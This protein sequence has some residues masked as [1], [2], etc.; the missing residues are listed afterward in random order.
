MTKKI[1]VFRQPMVSTPAANIVVAPRRMWSE[2]AYFIDY[3]KTLTAFGSPAQRCGVRQHDQQSDQPENECGQV[4]GNEAG[5][6]PGTVEPRHAVPPAVSL[7]P[8][9]T[10]VRRRAIKSSRI[11]TGRSQKGESQ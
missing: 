1:A 9:Q 3:S 10:W 6:K 11:A 2:P 4:G 7:R 8:R 5:R